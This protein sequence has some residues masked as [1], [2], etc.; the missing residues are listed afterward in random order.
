MNKAFAVFLVLACAGSAA[1]AQTKAAAPAAAGSMK[2]GMWELTHLIE[3]Q[4]SITKRTVTARS[5]YSADDVTSIERILPPQREFGM[6][7]ANK[8]IKTQ[9]SGTSWRATC[10]GKDTVL[11]GTATVVFSGDTYLAHAH[12]V[13]KSGGKSV[14]VEQ[15][16]SGKLIGECK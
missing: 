6:K 14:K 13:S 10:T 2:P 7:C 11:D 15:T 12:M 5:C 16:I 4:G 9:A 3:T 8:D 1:M